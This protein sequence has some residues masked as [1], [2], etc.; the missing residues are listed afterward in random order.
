[1]AHDLS[2]SSPKNRNVNVIQDRLYT[3]MVRNGM[4]PSTFMIRRRWNVSLWGDWRL[5]VQRS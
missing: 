3:E 4:Q 5:S 1:M 2:R